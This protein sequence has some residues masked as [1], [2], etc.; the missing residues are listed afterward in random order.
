MKTT[1][2]IVF[3]ACT[4]L[5]VGGCFTAK[6]ARKEEQP[7]SPS[8]PE[9]KKPPAPDITLKVG[10]INLTNLAKRVE[11]KDVEEFGH[12]L[13]KEKIDILTLQGVARYPGVETRIDIV[14]EI[15]A[16]TEMRQAFGETITLSGKQSG[17]A[18]FSLYPIKST[19]NTRY[20]GLHSS[21]FEAALQAVVDCG[22]RDIVVIVTGVPD[23]IVDDDR[24]TIANKLSSFGI[25]YINNPLIIAGNLPLPDTLRAS[26]QFDSMKPQS[27]DP[28][29]VWFSRGEAMKFQ[30]Q[31]MIVTPLGAMTV[32]QFAL[33]RQPG[34]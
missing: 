2:L 32:V 20:D 27:G 19:E 11:K 1:S 29:L 16:Q 8:V 4:I 17:N 5:T 9:T 26:E 30:S 14:N 28:P 6:D 12:L 21:S 13:K 10:S 23:S 24:R 25:V 3:V 31:D 7:T 34:P 22:V 15:G 33:F 18:V